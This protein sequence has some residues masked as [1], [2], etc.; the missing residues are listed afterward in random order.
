MFKKIILSI[1]IVLSLA[2]C[3]DVVDPGHV[4]VLV[5]NPYIFG[6]SGVDMEQTYPEGRHVLAFTSYMVQY[7]AQPIQQEEI[8]D[9]M[10]TIKQTPVD[11][12]AIIRYKIDPNKANSVHKNFSKDFYDIN[13]KKDFQNMLR[14]FARV[15]TVQDLTTNQQVTADG[16]VDVFKKMSEIVIAKKIPI[17][18]MAVTIGAIMPPEE[19]LI[20][21]ART[22]AQTQRA[23]TE[24]SRAMAETNRKDAETNK[25][26][27][28][29]AYM[30]EMGMTP[31]EYLQRLRIETDREIIETI[32]KKENVNIIFTMGGTQPSLTYPGKK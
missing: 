4:G 17:E 15:N 19:V 9:D 6:D 5:R 12:K 3:T 24:L 27:A 28:D 31:S 30:A 29:K 13:L 26:Q 10:P 25:A 16:E 2:G 32:K 23:T 22:E 20:E 14:D 7:N 11:F 8:F 18:I 21:T 1:C